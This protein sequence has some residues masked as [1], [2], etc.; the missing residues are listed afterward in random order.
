MT[1]KNRK[2][3]INFIF[4]KVLVVLFSQLKFL[5]KNKKDKENFQLYFS[6]SSAFGHE[7]T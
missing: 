5:I 4:F 3:L 2:K 1:H 7:N 6:S